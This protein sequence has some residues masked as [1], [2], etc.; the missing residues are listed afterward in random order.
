MD[1]IN[2]IDIVI[3][4]VD[5][6]DTIWRDEY[7]KYKADKNSD[8]SSAR[9]R[10]WGFLKYW[11][12]SIESYAPWVRKIHFITYGHL[13]KWLNINHPKLNIV[14]HSDFIPKKYL[15]TFSS[16]PIELNIHRIKGLSE[17]FIY[18]N[19]DIYLSHSLNK[20]D[21]FVNNIPV[22]T[23]VFGVIKN[24]DTSNF[25]PYIMLNMM[26]I[27][28]MNFDKKKMLKKDFSKWYSIKYGKDLLKNIYLSAW[29]AYTGF[30]NYHTCSA[31]CKSTFKKVWEL[32]EKILDETCLNKFRSKEDVNQY[33][34]RYWQLCEGKFVPHKS[35]S[36]YF[37]IG[38][39]DKKDIEK[40]LY[41]NKYKIICIND[42]PMGFDYEEQQKMLKSIFEKKYPNKSEYEINFI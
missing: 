16:H 7:N 37:T 29:S 4:W 30:M 1:K 20:E 39:K 26:A 28:N 33:L 35:N 42:D 25:M 9:Y 3:P 38:K 12:R 36:Y 40:I 23:G 22:D 18:F 15:P 11:F 31:F 17:N 13:P 14:T 21:F 8:N 32:N 34:M 2:P 27:I 19:D 6:S 24:T 41:D 5:G 10:D